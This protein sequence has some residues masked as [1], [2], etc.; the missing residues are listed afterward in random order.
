MKRRGDKSGAKARRCTAATDPASMQGCD[1]SIYNRD[2]YGY[3]RIFLYLWLQRSRPCLNPSREREQR[4]EERRGEEG[5]M[6]TNICVH[7]YVYI[8]GCMYVH[9]SI[10]NERRG[11]EG[12]M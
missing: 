5:G 3:G 11:E 12:G 10:Y 4:G 6:L 9:I 8:Y 2:R 1:P 7:V